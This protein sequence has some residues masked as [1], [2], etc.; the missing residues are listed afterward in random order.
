MASGSR[1]HSA[2]RRQPKQKNYLSRFAIYAVIGVVFVGVG[3]YLS[4]KYIFQ[5]VP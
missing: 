4:L 1:A 5:I 3:I 2:T